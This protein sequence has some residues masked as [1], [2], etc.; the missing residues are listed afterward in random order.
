MAGKTGTAQNSAWQGPWLVHRL[1]AGRQPGDRHRSHHGGGRTRNARW[2]RTSCK[3]LRRYVLGPEAPPPTP[4]ELAVPVDSAPRTRRPRTRRCVPASR[5]QLSRH[6]S[7]RDEAG[8]RVRPHAGASPTLLLVGFGLLMLYSAGQTDVPTRAAGVW[9]RQLVW[10]GVGFVAALL[11][12]Q[13]SPAHPRMGGAGALRAR[14]PAAARRARGRHRCRTTAESSHSWLSIGGVQDRPAVGVRQARHRADAGAVSLGAPGAAPLPA[15][16]AGAGRS[17][18]ACRS[19]WCSSSPTWAAPW[20]S[21][22]SSS[23]CC[24]GPAPGRCCCSSSPRPAISLLLGFST[25]GWMLWMIAL[26]AVLAFYRPYILGLGRG[27][28]RQRRSMGAIAIPIWS[29]LTPYQQNRLLTFLNPE[30]DPAEGRL[31]GDP[32]EGGASG[33]AAGSGPATPRDRRSG[34]PSCRSST[35][36][37]FSRS[38]G[39]NWAS[40]VS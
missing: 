6:G 32:V 27:L 9:H 36:T 15:R 29:R 39:R 8:G 22:G 17:S 40:S 4:A 33:P 16:P 23:R 2:R 37:S 35:P 3:A 7:R 28:S 31:S 24:S 18:S 19:C 34:S 12:Y 20:C 26:F 30:V 38:S 14:H 21:S 25:L 10:S 1:R 13:I 5:R 11:V